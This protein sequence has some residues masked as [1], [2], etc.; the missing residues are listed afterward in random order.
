MQ[1][2]KGRYSKSQKAAI[3]YNVR[4]H[5]HSRYKIDLYLSKNHILKDFIV[6]SGVLRPEKMSALSLAQWL[7]FHNSIYKN[8]KILDMGCGTGIQGIAM[9]EGNAKKIVL[10]DISSKAVENTK[11][12]IKKFKLI[13]KT[14]VVKGDLFEKVKGKFDLI[15]FNHPFII[16]KRKESGSIMKSLIGKGD[17]LSVFFQDAKKHLRKG[18]SIIMSYNLPCGKAGDP[19]IQGPKYGFNIVSFCKVY[20]YDSKKWEDT[21]YQLKLVPK[22]EPDKIK[23]EKMNFKR[24][25]EE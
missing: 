5:K 8:K 19:G 7:F 25:F 10:S 13:K 1:V 23:I 22:K 11:E 21:I 15:V 6:H 4:E 16:S 2:I 12:N 20:L 17:L 9:A 24:R 14:T 3:E 18:G